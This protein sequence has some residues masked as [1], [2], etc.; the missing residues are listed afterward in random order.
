[1]SSPAWGNAV[2]SPDDPTEETRFRVGAV[3]NCQGLELVYS[4]GVRTARLEVELDSTDLDH[5][6][7]AVADL[8]QRF[9]G[10]QKGFKK[11]ETGERS[12]RGVFQSG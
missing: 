2:A 7:A 8:N 5:A 4:D 9:P 12:F 10:D 6:K 11:L 1:M 3:D